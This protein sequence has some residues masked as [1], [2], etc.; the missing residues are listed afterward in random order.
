MVLQASGSSAVIQLLQQYMSDVDAMETDRFR[1]LAANVASQQLK[2]AIHIYYDKERKQL[3]GNAQKKYD[4]I[5]AEEAVVKKEPSGSASHN[6]LEAMQQMTHNAAM[7]QTLANMAAMHQGFPGH[8]LPPNMMFP[9]GL[10]QPG[11][12]PGFP[13]AGFPGPLP[14]LPFPSG[15]TVPPHLL[16]A[17]EVKT[18]KQEKPQTQQNYS[19][20]H[21]TSPDSW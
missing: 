13:G 1:A 10:P 17:S 3:C 2:E 7:A 8:H 15:L 6:P 9:G 18:P 21:D 11:L 16:G 19:T 20:P 12:F 5:L 4:D 14:G